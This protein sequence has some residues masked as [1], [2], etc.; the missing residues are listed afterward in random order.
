VDAN[1]M[2]RGNVMWKKIRYVISFVLCCLVLTGCNDVI[3]LSDEQSTL[4]AEYAAELLLKHDVDYED[5]VDEGEKALEDL[6]EQTTEEQLSGD[7]VTEEA[8]TEAL[9]E[10]E[11]SLQSDSSS[12]EEGEST[13]QILGTESDIAKIAGVQGASITYKDYLVTDQYPATGEEEQYLNLEASEG[14]QLLVVRFQ[15][16]N[17]T[18]DMV[19]VSMIDKDVDYRIVCNGSK[20]AKP[21]L[22]ILM[23]DLNNLE[24]S[25]KPG[26]EQEA[27]LV[28]QVSDT[29]K[30]ALDTIELK[31]NYDG[32]DNVVKIR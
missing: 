32:V 22:T 5:R 8:T 17:V 24:T 21:M 23:E 25:V 30:D 4:I 7:N 10:D 3:D 2:N 19:D 27:V 16:T 15:V 13:E 11:S 20:A 14:Y 26:E 6:D 9:P 12:A 1:E 28:F 31:V 18:E 29:M